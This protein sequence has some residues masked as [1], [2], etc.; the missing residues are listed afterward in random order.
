VA[1]HWGEE[2]RDVSNKRQQTLGR[3][4]IDAGADV[5]IGHHPHVVEEIELYRGKPIFYSL[6]NFIFDQYF[7]KETQ[8]GLAVKISVGDKKAAYELIPVDLHKSQPKRMSS[9]A[10]EKWLEELSLRS[11]KELRSDIIQG[12]FSLPR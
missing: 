12:G 7:S 5:I 10:E 9:D 1:I 6:G 11:A 3:A 2:Y 8:E 4:L